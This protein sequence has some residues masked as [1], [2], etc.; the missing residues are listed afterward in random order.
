VNEREAVKVTEA[1]AAIVCAGAVGVRSSNGPP[2]LLPP[3]GRPAMVMFEIEIAD[4]PLFVYV[5][6]PL[7]VSPGATMVLSSASGDEIANVPLPPVLC[8]TVNVVDGPSCQAPL[9]S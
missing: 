2:A 6:V 1:P 3:G 9:A 4:D 8:A 7:S 5:T